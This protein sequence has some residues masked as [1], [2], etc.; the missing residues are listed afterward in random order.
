MESGAISD[1]QVTASSQQNFQYIHAANHSRLHFQQNGIKA[2]GWSAA[3]NNS[4]QW[5]QVDLGSHDYKVT[6][7]ATQGRHSTN[8]QQWVTKYKLQY[9]NDAMTFW[10]YREQGMTTDKVKIAQRLN[11]QH[12]CCFVTFA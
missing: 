12:M 2:G 10:Y 6:R 9:S 8:Y 4:H 1:A 11:V 5:L 3:T 7:I